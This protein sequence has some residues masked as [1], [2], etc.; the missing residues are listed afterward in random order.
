MLTGTPLL[1]AG[2][3]DFHVHSAVSPDAGKDCTLER[4]VTVAEGLGMKEIGLTDHLLACADGAPPGY[5]AG[6]RDS[7]PHRALCGAIRAIRSPVK[8]YASWE[9]D[10]FD[11]GT[12]SFDPQKHRAS[13]DYVLLAHHA[14]E[15]V[16]DREPRDLARYLARITM[17]MAREPYGNIIA[18]PFYFPRPAERHAKILAAVSDA[19]FSEIFHAMRENGKAAEITPYQ[20]HA[21]LRGVEGMKR[22]YAVARS[23]GVRFTLDSDAHSL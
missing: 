7:A 17:E 9:V 11:G 23:T 19:E 14:V 8:V 4:I 12:Y 3:S 13:L 21:D 1:Q 18:H 6:G 5:L 22:M 10:Y 20:F 16:A 2:R 15:H